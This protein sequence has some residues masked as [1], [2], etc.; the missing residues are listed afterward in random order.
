MRLEQ[1]LCYGLHIK[2][3]VHVN[4]DSGS[5]QDLHLA[6]KHLRHAVSGRS[7]RLRQGKTNCASTL[8][9]SECTMTSPN[10]P[11]PVLQELNLEHAAWKMLSQKLSRI[12]L[13]MSDFEE[14]EQVKKTREKEM[15]TSQGGSQP[16]TPKSPRKPLGSM[17]IKSARNATLRAS[18]PEH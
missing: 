12:T 13:K 11:F 17:S 15:D 9:P 18:T 3:H 16:S 10:T 7:E 14:Y 8:V 5:V 6:G 4:S 1:V 2:T